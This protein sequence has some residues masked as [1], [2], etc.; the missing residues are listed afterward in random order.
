MGCHSYVPQIIQWQLILSGSC[1]LSSGPSSRENLSSWNEG[2][3]LHWVY[4]LLLNGKSVTPVKIQGEEV[5]MEPFYKYLGVHINN[6][7]DRTNK[8]Y[9][10]RGGRILFFITLTSISGGQHMV[11]CRSVQGRKQHSDG[12]RQD[13]YQTFFILLSE[14]GWPWGCKRLRQTLNQIPSSITLPIPSMVMYGIYF[15]TPRCNMKVSWCSFF[16]LT[17][18]LIHF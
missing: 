5:D 7:L 18:I 11:L 12:C 13:L 6:R 15:N 8:T 9:C 3:H 16:P 17:T 1:P 14:P 2:C 10:T 4:Y